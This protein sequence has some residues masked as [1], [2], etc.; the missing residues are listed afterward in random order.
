MTAKNNDAADT[1]HEPEPQITRE[2]VERVLAVGRLL[3]SVLTDEELD[4]LREYLNDD[5][6]DRTF[7]LDSSGQ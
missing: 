3:M 1:K 2:D 5:N 7:Q 6:P 4:R